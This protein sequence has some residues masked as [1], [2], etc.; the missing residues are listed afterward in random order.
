MDQGIKGRLKDMGL[1]DII[2]VLSMGRKTAAVNIGSEQGAGMIFV[3]DGNV[4]HAKFRELSGEDAAY[5]L[6]AWKD[7]EFSV[8]M[9][10]KP[11]ARTI[12]A[13]VEHIL[14]EGMKR[15][16]ETKQG[17]FDKERLSGVG[18]KE[19]IQ[20]IKSLIEMGILTKKS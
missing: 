19:S 10:V 5:N 15:L 3:E 1:V 16:D 6:L 20:L 12:S 17:G 2:Q 11:E 4:V 18:E 9:D 13:N 7:G 14:L 8:E